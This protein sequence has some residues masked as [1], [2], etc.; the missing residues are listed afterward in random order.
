MLQDMEETNY[1][2]VFMPEGLCARCGEHKP[3][4]KRDFDCYSRDGIYFGR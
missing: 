2:D 1:I 3:R 4:I